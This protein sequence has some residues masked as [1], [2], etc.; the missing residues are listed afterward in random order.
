MNDLNTGGNETMG[1]TITVATAVY[2]DPIGLQILGQSLALYHIWPSELIVVDNHPT[3]EK[4]GKPSK[5]TREIANYVQGLGGKYVPMP[6][7]VGTAVPRN[8]CVAEATSDVVIVCDSH[9]M[10]GQHTLSAIQEYFADDAHRLDIVS[11]PLLGRTRNNDGLLQVRATHY[12]DVWRAQMWGIWSQAWRCV[13][14]QWHFDVSPS[15]PAEAGLQIGPDG[16]IVATPQ[17]LLQDPV[18]S[19]WS[20]MPVRTRQTNCP[21]C[22]QVLPALPFAKH[23]AALSAAGYLRKA[24]S[25]IDV[26]SF[27]IPGMGLGM[28]AVWRTNWLGFPAEMRGFGGGE[29]HLH[30]QYRR[31]G[32]RAVCLPRAT[33]WH[34]F[35]R[36]T[37]DGKVPYPLQLWDKVRNYV[38]WRRHLD[39]P[40]DPVHQH[41][42]GSEV[43]LSQ[44]QWDY[45]IADPIGRTE[46]PG[47]LGS[48]KAAK[49]DKKS[50]AGKYGLPPAGSDLESIYA[51]TLTT[52]RD[53]VDHLPAIRTLASQCGSVVSLVKRREWDVA[54]LAGRPAKYQSHNAESDVL[55]A[56]LQAIAPFELDHQDSLAVNP[57]PCDLLIV[58]TVHS[59][60]RL[61][62][63]LRRWGSLVS[64]WIAL[65]GT[66]A[67]GETAEKKAGLGL[68]HAV[69]EWCKKH[70]AWHPVYRD[71]RQY[72]LTVLSCDPHERTCDR[73][74]GFELHQIFGSLGVEM[75]AG[76]SCRKRI[77]QMNAWGA[78]GC[79]E[80]FQEIVDGLKK[81]QD[82][83]SWGTKFRAAMGTVKTGL[84][85]RINPLDPLPSLVEEAIRRTEADDAAWAARETK[86][87]A[88]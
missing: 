48:P 56:Q 1:P 52:K 50:A 83:Y 47:S 67:F 18:C 3:Q 59:A 5:A 79:R 8:R 55:H 64:R 26:D 24:W 11:G 44:A 33:W 35:H 66:E 53:C 7:P 42:V 27:E 31:R 43:V 86:L 4:D 10:L 69:R 57:V 72:G 65:R 63:E 82:K 75:Q 30:E 2:D 16:T 87:Q 54:I 34:L 32:G 84:V 21:V 23:E 45:L 25:D 12:A 85:F 77:K 14:G 58:D 15:E 61:R 6:E 22:G 71:D 81:D 28:F 60:D 37:P 51:W 9:I 41:F 36:A 29:L 68:N 19:Y 76:C 78:A 73:G 46:W 38:I 39:L 74:P 13:C 20:M 17:L 49:V 40:L 88:A 70:P 62:Q 80:H